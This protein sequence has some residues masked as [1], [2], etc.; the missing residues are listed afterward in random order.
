MNKKIVIILSI[1]VVIVAGA[2]VFNPR[3]MVIGGL[4]GGPIGPE[5]SSYLEE[6]RCFGIKRDFCPPWPDAGCD[7]LC[8]GV[9]YGRKCF[10]QTND[11]GIFRKEAA[12]CR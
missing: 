1:V 12:E 7:H 5:E 8:Y 4:S 10:I 6:Y 3:D 9:V 2:L 11:N